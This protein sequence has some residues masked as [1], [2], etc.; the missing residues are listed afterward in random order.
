MWASFPVSSCGCFFL[1]FSVVG[2]SHCFYLLMLTSLGFCVLVIVILVLM[3]FL[4]TAFFLLFL[5]ILFL[6]LFLHV[7]FIFHFAVYF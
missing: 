1:C 4:L 7:L 2:S 5:F 3:F 6:L